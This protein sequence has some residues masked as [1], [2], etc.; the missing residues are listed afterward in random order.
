[1]YGLGVMSEALESQTWWKQ[2]RA[3]ID[4]HGFYRINP[5]YG[6]PAETGEFWVEND[7]VSLSDW[8]LDAHGYPFLDDSGVVTFESINTSVKDS[9]SGEILWDEVRE[10]IDEIQFSDKDTKISAGKAKGCIKRFVDDFEPGTG[11]VVN[12]EDGQVFARVTGEC[13]FDPDHEVAVV[14]DDHVFH[15]KAEFLRGD[16][17]EVI[18]FDTDSLPSGLCPVQN[19][20]VEA[21]SRWLL[22]LTRGVEFFTQE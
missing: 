3:A 22:E 14:E 6:N 16:D 10:L 9:M 2:L 19:S 8:A 1:M 4:T 18:T 5:G 21:D 13:V 7:I 12:L 15:R 17:G 20:I 11:L